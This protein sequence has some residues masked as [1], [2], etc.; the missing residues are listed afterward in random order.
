MNNRRPARPCFR[1]IAHGAIRV[2]R[3]TLARIQP[4]NG[5]SGV[6]RRNAFRGGVG[7]ESPTLGVWPELTKR[8]D[9]TDKRTKLERVGAIL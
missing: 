9:L 1:F 2:Q 4:A 8:P 6:E 3:R 5:W 7:R